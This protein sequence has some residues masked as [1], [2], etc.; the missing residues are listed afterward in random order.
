VIHELNLNIHGASA[1]CTSEDSQQLDFARRN[2]GPFAC[3]LGHDQADIEGT[4]S[5]PDGRWDVQAMAAQGGATCRVGNGLTVGPNVAYWTDADHFIYGLE[6]RDDRIKA[7]VFVNKS[8][9]RTVRSIGRAILRPGSRQRLD[10]ILRTQAMRLL[11]HFP[12]F[13]LLEHNQG[14][15]VIH[16]AAVA[17]DGR[18]VVLSGLDGVG[19]STLAQYLCRERGFSLLSD[20]FLLTDG[21]QIF[22][23]PEMTRLANDSVRSLGIAETGGERIGDRVFLSTDRLTTTMKADCS[24]VILNRIGQD[25]RLEPVS[26]SSAQ[27]EILRMRHY[28]SEFIDYGRFRTLFGYIGGEPWPPSH[29]LAVQELSRNNPCFILEKNG[30]GRLTE[31]A[32]MVEQCI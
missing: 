6:Y 17:R 31:T 32:D 21:K 23:F 30:L 19:K 18:V 27:A 22:A 7:S 4:Y 14:I 5:L 13:S 9:R 10:G 2:L 11:I 16:G 26:S 28:L 29:D 24:A 12:V 1:R 20:N 15:S 3:E 8:N 25:C